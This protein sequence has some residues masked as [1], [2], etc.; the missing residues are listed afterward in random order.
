MLIQLER[1]FINHLKSKKILINNLSKLLDDSYQAITNENYKF[2]KSYKVRLMHSD[3]ISHVYDE[4]VKNYKR[5]N[6]SVD[7]FISHDNIFEA[8]P[9]LINNKNINNT[10]TTNLVFDSKGKSIEINYLYHLNQG[11]DTNTLK[12]NSII[13]RETYK[14]INNDKDTI[15]DKTIKNII[16]RKSNI[17]R[18][19]KRDANFEDI[20][21]NIKINESSNNEIK[22]YL[23]TSVDNNNISN[24][25]NRMNTNKVVK[26]SLRLSQISPIRKE[27]KDNLD[28]SPLFSPNSNLFSKPFAKYKV[29]KP[30]TPNSFLRPISK[31]NKYERNDKYEKTDKYENNY[32]LS[33]NETETRLETKANVLINIIIN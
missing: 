7:G 26:R 12:N 8:S 3:K 19:D 9:L 32:T 16:E 31:F 14:H 28:T 17:F 24:V 1:I 18:N 30:E 6:Y 13:T 2:E 22:E 15:E 5:N 4:I 23:N 25:R 29:I 11:I 27:D 33:V 21:K 20:M 10:N